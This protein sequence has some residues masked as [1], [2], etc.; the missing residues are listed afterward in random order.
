MKKIALLLFLSLMVIFAKAQETVNIRLTDSA[1]ASVITC[2]AGDEFY[3]SFGHSAIRI[4]D[5]VQ[6]IDV[7]YNYGTFDFGIPHFYWN[8]AR[9]RLN[10]SL[11]RSSFQN[12]LFEYAYEGRSVW[13][14]RLLLSS[15]EV[16][17]LFVLLETNYLPEYRHYW[18][19]FFRDN[20]A[21]RVRDMIQN[22][23]C[24]RTLSPE[25]T[26]DTNLTYRNMIYRYTESRLLW[27]RL[28]VDIALGQHCDHRCSNYEYMFSPIEMMHQLDTMLV[29]D[30]RQPLVEPTQ[31]LLAETREPL[32]R[33]INPTLLFWLIL[34]IVNLLT[35]YQWIKGWRLGWLDTILF[36]LPFIISILVIFLWFFTDH[37]CTK[38]NLNI[39]WASP[40]FLYFAIRHRKSNRWII[41]IQLF[42]LLAAM[43]MT[44]GPLPQQLNSAIL[45]IC[46]TLFIRLISQL[47]QR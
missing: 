5:T 17:N 24:H 10:Y 12:F 15:Q 8:F 30:T 27:W 21:T 46:L 38:P 31:E 16:N 26:A 47:K 14:Q 42:M 40:L 7:V 25:I 43:V 44:L 32:P 33:S 37:Y 4:C 36:I 23:L 19:D 18:Y 39:L 1:F 20:C 2:G 41:A 35:I 13:E 29:S 6:N 9:G 11:S 3:S 22:C 28:G 34:A 45:P